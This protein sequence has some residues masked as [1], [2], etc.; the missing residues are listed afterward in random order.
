[1]NK[2]CENTSNDNNSKKELNAYSLAGIGIG[3]IVGSGF[4]L[5]S[6]LAIR[7]AGPAVIL[8]FLVGG[9]IMSQVLGAMTSI[10]IN[11]PVTGSFRVYTEQFL[12]KFM[13]YLLGWIIYISSILGI[14]SEAMAAAIFLKYWFTRIP[15]ALLALGVIIL[16]I[17]INRL[18]MRYFSYIESGTAVLKIL[19]IVIFVGIGVIFLLSHGIQVTPNPFRS[20]NNFFPNKLSGI[21]QAMLVVIFTYSGISTIAMATSDVKKPCLSIP[22][23]TIIVTAGLII[24]YTLSMCIIILTMNWSNVNIASSP[25]IQSLKSMNINWASSTINAIILIATFSVMIGNYYSCNQAII[26]LSESKEAPSIF[27][28]T[29]KNFYWYAWLLTGISSLIVVLLSFSVSAKLFNYLVSACSYYSFFNWIVNLIVYL[30]WLK[31]RS[32]DEKYTSPLIL[33]RWG[34]YGTIIIVILFFV[35]SLKVQDFRIGFYS[36]AIITVLISISYKLVKR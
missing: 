13:G 23:A 35:M 33:G 10:S 25:I 1:M 34:A 27:K 22:K 11:R 31:K 5:G 4:F 18:N 9:F 15:I 19:T 16:V 14:A 17:L 36:A 20:V 6:G 8:A 26:S 21:L 28:N 7:E 29:K 12:G 2:S 24:L 32:S 30:L 3:G